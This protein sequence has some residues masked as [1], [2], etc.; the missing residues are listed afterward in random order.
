MICLEFKDKLR[1]LIIVSSFLERIWSAELPWFQHVPKG[2]CPED[3]DKGFQSLCHRL[4]LKP[5]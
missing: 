1:L 5:A 3:L 2:F 4:A